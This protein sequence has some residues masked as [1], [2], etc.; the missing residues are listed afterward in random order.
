MRR[1]VSLVRELD[2]LTDV[3]SDDPSG[4]ENFRLSASVVDQRGVLLIINK[5]KKMEFTQGCTLPASISRRPYLLH[6]SGGGFG[7]P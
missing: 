7:I 4:T 6:L 3:T 5:G 2:V 1:R